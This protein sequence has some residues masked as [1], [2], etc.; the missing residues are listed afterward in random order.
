MMK[1]YPGYPNYKTVDKIGGYHRTCVV[2]ELLSLEQLDNCE[3][4]SIKEQLELALSKLSKANVE[5]TDVILPDRFDRILS[6]GLKL[7]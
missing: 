6:N 7:S 4:A 2:I 3:L 5:K 1:P